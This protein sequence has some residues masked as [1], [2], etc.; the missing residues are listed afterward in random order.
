[1]IWVYAPVVRWVV[2]HCKLVIGLATVAIVLTL[3]AAARLLSSERREFM[4]PLNEG[5]L[6]YMPTAPPGM[7]DSPPVGCPVRSMVA[8]SLM[9]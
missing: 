5:A 2:V 6:L 8:G 9:T 1:M 4:P 3:P 7:S